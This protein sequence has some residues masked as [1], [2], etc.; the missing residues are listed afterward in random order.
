MEE[1]RKAFKERER[2]EE[3]K[4]SQQ[5]PKKRGFF[6]KLFGIGKDEEEQKID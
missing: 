4:R 3:Q 1:E 6:K 2:L 5:T